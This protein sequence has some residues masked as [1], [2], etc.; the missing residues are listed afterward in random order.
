MHS[1][2]PF[3]GPFPTQYLPLYP[4]FGHTGI[5]G[6]FSKRGRSAANFTNPSKRKASASAVEDPESKDMSGVESTADLEPL[7]LQEADKRLKLDRDRERAYF[8]SIIEKSELIKDATIRSEI[9]QFLKDPGSPG[10][11]A[12]A[13]LLTSET[14]L[15]ELKEQQETP[16]SIFL[17]L[18][19]PSATIKALFIPESLL[20][21]QRKQHP[22]KGLVLND[23][24]VVSAII[25]GD[26]RGSGLSPAVNG[27]LRSITVPL[28]QQ[29]SLAGSATVQPKTNG[30]VSMD[31]DEPAAAALMI[32]CG[33]R[34]CKE[35]RANVQELSLH[36][37][38]DHIQALESGATGAINRSKATQNGSEPSQTAA[39]YEADTSLAISDLSR[40]D[41]IVQLQNSYSSLKSDIVRM[42][43]E[44]TRSDKQAQ[45]LSTLYS[46]AIESSEENIKRLEAQLEWEMKKWDQY[47]EETRRMLALGGTTNVGPVHGLHPT[48][49]TSSDDAA[50]TL[51][52]QAEDLDLGSLSQSD[53]GFDKPMEAQAQNLIHTIQKLLLA[54][55]EKQSQLEKQNQELVGKR[56]ALESEHALLD[57]RYQETLAQ[58]ALLE[59][60][61]H[62]TTEALRIRAKG[63]E[64]CRATIDQEQEHSRNVVEQLQAKIDELRQG[65]S[66]SPQPQHSLSTAANALLNST[67]QESDTNG[68]HIMAD[69]TSPPAATPAPDLPSQVTSSDRLSPMG[70]ELEQ[71][72]STDVDSTLEPLALESASSD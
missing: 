4:P 6:Q 30:D 31:V 55:R 61:D 17:A 48:T 57:Q 2:P 5:E 23:R 35:M 72:P 38:Q 51:P 20:E 18:D 21:Y 19:I 45:D 13:V 34:D 1:Q 64:E 22:E 16:G 33:W 63:V 9:L 46:I 26:L 10:L 71:M 14:W 7:E 56:R 59:A 37:Q 62:E 28:S 43:E 27:D 53:Q 41:Q 58:L 50:T 25:A 67:A 44:I 66:S 42:K 60:R 24:S 29:S 39:A 8:M 69:P 40:G 3:S 11:D 32:G 49:A 36:V 70:V 47:R 15:F 65:S 12:E 54:A 68:D 52:E